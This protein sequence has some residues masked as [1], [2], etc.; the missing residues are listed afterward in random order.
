MRWAAIV[1]HLIGKHMEKCAKNNEFFGAIF[2]VGGQPVVWD[3]EWNET[4]QTSPE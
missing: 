1:W 2:M 4:L 3:G